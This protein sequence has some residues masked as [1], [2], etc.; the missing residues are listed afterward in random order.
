MNLT[1]ASYKLIFIEVADNQI[2]G[3]DPP[4]IVHKKL[5]TNKLKQL[6]TENPIHQRNLQRIHNRP[7]KP[8]ISMHL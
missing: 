6:L 7:T 8:N 4:K 1:Y 3:T 2:T 5:D